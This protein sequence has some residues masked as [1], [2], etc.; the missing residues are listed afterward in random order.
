MY[1]NRASSCSDDMYLKA[2][3]YHGSS[4]SDMTINNMSSG[5]LRKSI[6]SDPQ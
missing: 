2:I 3:S 5:H 1:V 4:A 6:I